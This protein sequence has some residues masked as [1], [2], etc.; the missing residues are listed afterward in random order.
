MTGTVLFSSLWKDLQPGRSFYVEPPLERLFYLLCY[1]VIL[2][3]ENTRL[4]PN[5]AWMVFGCSLVMFVF[6]LLHGL[7]IQDGSQCRTYLGIT[8]MI[9]PKLCMNAHWK[10]PCKVVFLAWIGNPRWP[11]MQDPNCAWMVK[12]MVKPAHAVTCIKRFP[13]SCSDIENFIWI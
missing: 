11:P 2:C 12:W 8:N 1:I 4:Y 13:F 9:E 10:V 3:K 6:L 7:E 5:S